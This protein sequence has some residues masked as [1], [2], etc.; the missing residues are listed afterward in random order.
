M[1]GAAE[2]LK[3]IPEGR[4]CVVTSGTRYL[5]TARLKLGESAHSESAGFSG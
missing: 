2:L 4:W 5:A 3:S 1:P